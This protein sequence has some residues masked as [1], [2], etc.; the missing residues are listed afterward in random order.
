M[1]PRFFNERVMFTTENWKRFFVRP[2]LRY[3]DICLLGPSGTFCVSSRSTGKRK[4]LRKTSQSS[5]FPGSQ[6]ETSLHHMSSGFRP[7]VKLWHKNK[8]KGNFAGAPLQLPAVTLGLGKVHRCICGYS[9]SKHRTA[10]Q[11]LSVK[12]KGAESKEMKSRHVFIKFY[13]D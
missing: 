13:P 10:Y 1:F 3:A 8:G 12:L 6:A 9:K 5:L 4:D 2:G 11:L 7:F